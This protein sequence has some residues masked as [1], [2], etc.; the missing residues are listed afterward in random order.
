M[1]CNP[2]VLEFMEQCEAALKVTPVPKLPNDI[3]MNIIKL[4]WGS[5]LDYHKRAI[6]TE[7]ME[8]V[9]F[10]LH[11][12]LA[13][14]EQYHKN[15]PD[16][17]SFFD[18]SYCDMDAN[19]DEYDASYYQYMFRNTVSIHSN[20]ELGEFEEGNYQVALSKKLKTLVS[21]RQ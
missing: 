12:D 19:S 5:T 9:H 10:G 4:A 14:C 18:S 7:H 21:V 13:F 16:E 3:I 17:L 11:R 2:E 8:M 6:P 1:S 20:Y 15:E